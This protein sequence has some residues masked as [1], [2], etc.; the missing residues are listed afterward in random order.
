MREILN[1]KKALLLDM[2][3]TFM[4]EED[5]FGENEDYSAYYH[6]I[7][8]EIDREKE[9]TLPASEVNQ[10]I[11][12]AY[13]YLDE[14]YP[15]ETYRLHFPSVETALLETCSQPLNR[16]EIDRLIATFSFHE[17]GIIP[18]DYT[19]ALHDLADRFT[20]AAVIDIWSPSV[21][22][23]ETFRQLE[24]E[25]LFAAIS[26]SSDHGIVK[27]SPLPFERV[28]KQLELSPEEALVIGD[29][30]RRDLGG[31][32]SAGIGTILVGTQHQD[33]LASFPNLL[34]FRDSVLESAY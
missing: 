19:A 13:Q 20:L 17:L 9:G 14:R 3:S 28:L 31:A 12:D 7:D 34:A 16:R 33:A 26:F 23:R 2:N 22:W 6:G 27:P 32:S 5:R 30:A 10:I 11:S 29:S 24:I 21:A 8:H 4:F 25:E 18:P 15:D 1:G